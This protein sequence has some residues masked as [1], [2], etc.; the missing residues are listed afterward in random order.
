MNAAAPGAEVGL[1]GD[2]LARAER[3]LEFGMSAGY[4]ELGGGIVS[5]ADYAAKPIGRTKGWWEQCELLR[6]LKRYATEHG[7]TDL[8]PAF[9]KSLELALAH[10]VDAEFGG[11][12]SCPVGAGRKDDLTGRKGSVWKVDYHTVGMY[13]EMLRP[14]R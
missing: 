8:W 12:Y 5:P 11:W 14:A 6:T 9:D 1:R 13:R 4:D 10:L 2:C 3:M 7:R